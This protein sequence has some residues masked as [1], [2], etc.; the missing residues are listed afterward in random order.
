MI[1]G[2]KVRFIAIEGGGF[3]K[4]GHG[5]VVS[6]ETD[7][8]MGVTWFHVM[9]EKGPIE[10]VHGLYVMRVVYESAE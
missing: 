9:G 2:Q 10:S 4:T 5:G 3:H 1:E 6:I 8:Q 7:H